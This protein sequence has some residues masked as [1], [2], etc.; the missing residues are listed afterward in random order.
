M[1]VIEFKD[2]DDLFGD[3]VWP[4]VPRVGEGVRLQ[5]DLYLVN[6]VLWVECSSGQESV[7]AVVSVSK[8]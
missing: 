5:D 6:Q 1:I 3:R 2:G 4:A 7:K 8:V